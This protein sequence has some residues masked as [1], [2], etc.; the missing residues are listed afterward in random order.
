MLWAHTKASTVR[1]PD[2]PAAWAKSFTTRL[3]F[4][5]MAFSKAWTVI[6]AG[7]QYRACRDPWRFICSSNF[8]SIYPRTR[9]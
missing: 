1:R 7:P 9:R 5:E 3:A 2:R 4:T 6:L 8:V